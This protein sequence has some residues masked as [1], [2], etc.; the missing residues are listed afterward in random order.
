MFYLDTSA[1]VPLFLAESYT[2]AMQSWVDREAPVIILGD[3]AAAEFCATVSRH[4]RMAQISRK[5]AEATLADFDIWRGQVRQ[6]MTSAADVARC[7]RL[8]RD[9]RLK[10]SAADALHLATAIVERIT[11]VTFDRRL[12]EASIV[13]NSPVIIPGR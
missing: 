6:R 9:F 1:I 3:F 2:T 5:V 12:A 11:L 4:S 7:E 8:V 10:L 13:L